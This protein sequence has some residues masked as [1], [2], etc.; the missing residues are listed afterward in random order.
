MENMS[1]FD[2]LG[3]VPKGDWAVSR[4]Y[5]VLVFEKKKRE[6]ITEPP[7]PYDKYRFFY[8]SSPDYEPD[9]IL[10]YGNGPTIKAT[11]PQAHNDIIPT[12]PDFPPDDQNE[13]EEEDAALMQLL[14][15]RA[16]AIALA[17]GQDAWDALSE[18]QMSSFLAKAAEEGLGTSA[19]PSTP[20]YPPPEHRFEPSSPDYPPP[21]YKFE[22][23]SP[24]YPPP[25]H[26][27]EP[28]SPDYPPPEPSSPDYPPP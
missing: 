6:E 18:E 27:L 22:P 13:D 16:K 11:S 12:S 3:A 17:G 7:Y 1:V 4:L 8:P 10:D 23:S 25:E 28:S 26:R 2:Y 14:Q 21:Q 24:D 20:D 19:V 5:A 9:S 15:R